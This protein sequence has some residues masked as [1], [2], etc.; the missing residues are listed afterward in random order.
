MTKTVDLTSLELGGYIAG[1][2]SWH[3]HD[4]CAMATLTAK[5]YAD[6][7]P[8]RKI[9]FDVWFS[10]EPSIHGNG[11][12]HPVVVVEDR[13]GYDPTTFD[14]GSSLAICHANVV[15]ANA[16]LGV[17]EAEAHRIIGTSMECLTA[18]GEASRRG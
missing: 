5:R 9:C 18:D 2:G 15:L 4:L 1:D 7:H 17:D 14:I 12:F 16:V 6:S 3:E 11:G 13:Q 10:R 8:G